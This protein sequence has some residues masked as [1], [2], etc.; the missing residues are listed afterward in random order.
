MEKIYF[1]MPAYN[2][3]ENIARTIEQWYPVVEQLNGVGECE[4]WL[5]IANDG[6]RDNTY[7]LMSDA[8]KEKQLTH[9]I[10]LEKSNGGHGHT[11]MYLYRYAIEQGAD[12]IFQ[13]DSDGQ[14]NPEEVWEMLGLRHDYDI[15]VGNRAHRQ[16]GMARVGVAAV[17]R[18]VVWM[19]LQVWV[20][21][22]NTPFRLMESR[23]L[24]AI[25]DILPQDFFLC[26]AAI[27]AVSKRW[28]YRMRFQ[29]ISFVPRKKGTNS[30]NLPKIFSIGWKAVMQ[31]RQLNGIL[32]R[33]SPK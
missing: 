5:V 26:N 7:E 24:K 12:Y 21:D 22:L 10:P 3:A 32:Q 11:V 14:T 2:E 17:L 23:K 30:I 25:T 28:K 4:A 19:F 9:F 15:Q 8:K 13:T 1:V 6:S 20:A 33:M 27:T 31:F 29:D 16:D 18:M